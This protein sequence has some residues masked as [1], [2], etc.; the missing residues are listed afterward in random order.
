MATSMDERTIHYV[1]KTIRKDLK[2]KKKHIQ[3][4]DPKTFHIASCLLFAP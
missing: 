2:K 4:L 3:S 1:I